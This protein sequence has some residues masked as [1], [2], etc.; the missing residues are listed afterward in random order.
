MPNLHGLNALA[1]LVKIVD[2]TFPLLARFSQNDTV[3]PT[4]SSLSNSVYPL[5]LITSVVPQGPFFIFASILADVAEGG[6][7]SGLLEFVLMIKQRPP[8]THEIST[9]FIEDTLEALC[10][11]LRGISMS[12]GLQVIF[13]GVLHE[14]MLSVQGAVLLNNASPF[15]NDD[16]TFLINCLRGNL[17]YESSLEAAELLSLK[18]VTDSSNATREH[19]LLPHFSSSPSGV[20]IPTKEEIFASRAQVAYD[21]LVAR[22]AYRCHD[23]RWGSGRFCSQTEAGYMLNTNIPRAPAG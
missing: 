15:P 11:D 3:K 16:V 12:E 13:V 9:S 20:K 1:S 7:V 19:G 8:P 5:H 2:P 17:T 18:L 23:S 10:D 21:R 22:S 6:V 4:S 14:V